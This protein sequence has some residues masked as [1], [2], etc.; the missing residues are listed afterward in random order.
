MN[1][2]PKQVRV[3]DVVGNGYF[4]PGLYM[5]KGGRSFYDECVMLGSTAAYLVRVESDLRVIKRWIGWDAPL[6]QMKPFED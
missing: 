4:S 6:L 1:E 3:C 2:Y 5:L